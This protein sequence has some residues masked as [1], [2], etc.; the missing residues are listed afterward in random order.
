MTFADDLAAALADSLGVSVD[1]SSFESSDAATQLLTDYQSFV[2]GLDGT[3]KATLNA[4]VE[5]GIDLSTAQDDDG[6][7]NLPGAP[8]LAMAAAAQQ[9]LDD[10]ATAFQTGIDTATNQA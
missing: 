6:P 9:P 10:V 2:D 4:L 3:S 1:G 8:L 5:A 7:L